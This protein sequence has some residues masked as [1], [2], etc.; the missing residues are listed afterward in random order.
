MEPDWKMYFPITPAELTCRWIFRKISPF[1]ARGPSCFFGRDKLSGKKRWPDSDF[2]GEDF[3]RES[4][5]WFFHFNRISSQVTLG[6]F[7]WKW[8][9]AAVIWVFGQHQ[10]YHNDLVGRRPSSC[11][12]LGVLEVGMAW[13]FFIGKMLGGSLEWGPLQNLH[14]QP[15]YVSL[16]GYLLGISSPF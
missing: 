10:A 15:R 4:L 13:Y 7:M 9:L 6:V 5:T 3:F 16:C 14:N 1:E 8:C 2:P 11:R 12:C